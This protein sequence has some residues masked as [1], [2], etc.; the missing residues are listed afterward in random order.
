MFV[1]TLKLLCCSPTVLAL[2]FSAPHRLERPVHGR[3]SHCPT[4]SETE[5]KCLL[6]LHTTATRL[7][8]YIAQ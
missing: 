2:T 4:L 8:Y 7:T 5:N 1:R 3:L 6:L